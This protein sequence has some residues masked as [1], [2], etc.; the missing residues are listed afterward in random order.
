MCLNIQCIYISGFKCI[1][2]TMASL[3]MLKKSAENA[4]VRFFKMLKL[5]KAQANV[6]ISLKKMQKTYTHLCVR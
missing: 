3:K 2:L 5:A 4:S 6:N 1:F